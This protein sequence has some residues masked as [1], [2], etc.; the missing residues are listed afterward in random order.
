MLFRSYGFSARLALAHRSDY[1]E[2]LI[3]PGI[4]LYVSPRN[5]I[6][7]KA[8]YEIREGLEVFGSI[9]N[10]NDAPLE[11]YLGDEDRVSS[12]EIYSWSA[13]VGLNVRF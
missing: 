5:Q 9:L 13:A 6:D 1:L 7:F 12:R 4:D 11:T 8:S 3:S 2:A 10:I